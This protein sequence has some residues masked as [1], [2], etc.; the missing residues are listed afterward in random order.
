M[1]L[2][3]S[4]RLA[5]WLPAFA[6]GVG[7]AAY[8]QP[9]HARSIPAECA[10][11][12]QKT[13]DNTPSHYS[14]S[15]LSLHLNNTNPQAANVTAD[16]VETVL[17]GQKLPEGASL[18]DMSLA[19]SL[20]LLSGVTGQHSMGCSEE[21]FISVFEPLIEHLNQGGKISIVWKNF[22]ASYNNQTTHFATA[23]IELSGTQGGK[24]YQGVLSTSGVYVTPQ[25]QTAALMPQD[26]TL[27]FSLPAKDLPALMTSLSGRLSDKAVV[28]VTISKLEADKSQIHLHGDGT[29]TLTSKSSH[30]LG[31]GHLAIS[32][33]DDLI[34]LLQQK[35]L[36]KAS[37]VA[38]LARLVAHHSDK[39]HSWD[40]DWED[41][42]L[43]VNHVPL[44]IQ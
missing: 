21:Y 15:A 16:K 23:K 44:P 40:I 43:T 7:A 36:R 39:T 17:T 42:V 14:A 32:N 6:F 9:A 30:I 20:A 4:S 35:G 8:V 28:P 37:T 25:S 29:V 11:T 27:D 38:I 5:M 22:K 12:T 13:V 24:T 2:R 31:K 18:R 33:Y 34:A 10:I 26:A 3:L 19:A 41:G 1:K